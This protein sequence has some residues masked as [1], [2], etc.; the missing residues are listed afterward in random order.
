MS[1]QSGCVGILMRPAL[2]NAKSI[3]PLCRRHEAAAT[4]RLK[5][6]SD[7]GGINE[8][9]ELEN[10]LVA[11]VFEKAEQSIC[12]VLDDKRAHALY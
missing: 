5:G 12:E 8:L 7:A 10:R 6:R 4:L 9:L 2:C 1:I 11:G 3:L